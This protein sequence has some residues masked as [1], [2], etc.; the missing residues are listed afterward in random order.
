MCVRSTQ[1]WVS[2]KKK[3]RGRL[4]F[5][6]KNGSENFSI[7]LA[8][9]MTDQSCK[10]FILFASHVLLD[11]YSLRHHVFLYVPCFF[12]TLTSPQVLPSTSKQPADFYQLSRKNTSFV[13][14]F[15]LCARMCINRNL[16]YRE[17]AARNGG[18]K[19]TK[20]QFSF[21]ES[22]KEERLVGHTQASNEMRLL[23]S[24]R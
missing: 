17:I 4:C 20:E 6:G 21:S 9:H 3:S 12:N 7:R 5:R 2:L 8:K 23:S 14:H 18:A 13:L 19:T 15:N 1:E 11:I 16:H 10:L 22:H 24:V